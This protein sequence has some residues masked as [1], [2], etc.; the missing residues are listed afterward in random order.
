MLTHSNTHIFTLHQGLLLSNPQDDREV[1][2]FNTSDTIKLT[3]DVSHV[4]NTHTQ[5][6]MA[7]YKL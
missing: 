5:A 7:G 6:H 3:W 2:L 4:A 1:V